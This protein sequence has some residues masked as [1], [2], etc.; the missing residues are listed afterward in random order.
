MERNIT[1]LH[2]KHWNASEQSVAPIETESQ[3]VYKK[4]KTN[5]I[6]SS[7]PVK[8]SIKNEDM[9][10]RH[11][12]HPFTEPKLLSWAWNQQRVS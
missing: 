7:F 12:T 2:Q 1:V 5:R 6:L 11:K 9:T 3:E 4:K 10:H 8:P